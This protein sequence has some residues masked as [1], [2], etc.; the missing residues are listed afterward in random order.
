VILTAA[1][2]ASLVLFA[3]VGVRLEPDEQSRAAARQLSLPDGAAN[4]GTT[5]YSQVDHAIAPRSRAKRHAAR[6]IAS[7]QSAFAI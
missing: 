1:L 6:G 7:S 2:A 3:P 5:P 4:S